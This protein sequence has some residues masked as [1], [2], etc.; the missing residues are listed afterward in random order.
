MMNA[1]IRTQRSP[2]SAR[3]VPPSKPREMRAGVAGHLADS[4]ARA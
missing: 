4:I 1:T 2:L 3:R